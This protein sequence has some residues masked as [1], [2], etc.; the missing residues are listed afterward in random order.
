MSATDAPIGV[1]QIVDSATTA[2]TTTVA[3]SSHRVHLRIET[4]LLNDGSL[5]GPLLIL[6]LIDRPV[7]S[8]G[9]E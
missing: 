4:S 1:I 6:R 2:P 3:Q 9:C 8:F 5:S 7:K